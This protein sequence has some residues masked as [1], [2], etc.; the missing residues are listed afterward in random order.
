MLLK[1]IGMC[2]IY[3]LIG[4]IV[5]WLTGVIGFGNNNGGNGYTYSQVIIIGVV[6]C[7][8]SYYLR[9]GKLRKEHKGDESKEKAIF[10]S[11]LR[12]KIQFIVTTKDFKIE[13]IFHVIAA[14]ITVMIPL[15][16]SAIA[17]SFAAVFAVKS[18]IITIILWMIF[19]PIFMVVL[20]IASWLLAYN[21]CYKRKEI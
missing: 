17:Y 21:K 19:V 7:A 15:T 2:A 3:F 8:I 18:T 5:Y 13:T 6:L 16:E 12:E 14:F 4:R 10:N 20:N 9:D 1:K 11:S